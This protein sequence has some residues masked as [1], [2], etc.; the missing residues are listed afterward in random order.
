[1]SSI[2]ILPFLAA[3]VLVAS[4]FYE[5]QKLTARKIVAAYDSGSRQ[6]LLNAMMQSGKTGVFMY[7]AFMLILNR[8][9]DRVVILCGSDENEL[10]AQLVAD[11]DA[12]AETFA[13]DQPA[14]VEQIFLLLAH[15]KATVTILKSSDLKSAD[16][17]STRLNSSH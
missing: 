12:Y 16:R 13:R 14:L 9:V 5:E 1:M 8:K 4:R 3:A 2:G 6:V 10:H 17:K 15:L 11:R 7:V